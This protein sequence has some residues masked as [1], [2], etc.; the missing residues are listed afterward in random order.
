MKTNP[1]KY[2]SKFDEG[3]AVCQFKKCRFCGKNIY[4]SEEEAEQAKTTGEVMSFDNI[5]LVV[6]KC[7]H[8]Q[9]WHLASKK[10]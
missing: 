9:G 6:Y 3:Q 10:V 1:R 4:H 5:E 2:S 8:G 7:P